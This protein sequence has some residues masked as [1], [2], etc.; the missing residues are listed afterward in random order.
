MGSSGVQF[1]Q[2]IPPKAGLILNKIWDMTNR[3]IPYEVQDL[4]PAEGGIDPE[5]DMGYDE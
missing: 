4:L 5:Q 2:P 3:S 1:G